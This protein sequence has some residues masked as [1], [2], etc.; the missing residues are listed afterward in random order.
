M[1]E[2][3]RTILQTTLLMDEQPR[4][5]LGT[6]IANLF[7]DIPDNDEPLPELPRRTIQAA[8][9]QRMIILDTN[10]DLGAHATG[11]EP[12]ADCLVGQDTPATKFGRP[13]STVMEIV[14]VCFC[15]LKAGAGPI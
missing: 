13:R 2:E 9:F 11:A 8:Q 6:E 4:Y 10:V 5:G 12:I 1:E 7:R 15:Y 3:A 14:R